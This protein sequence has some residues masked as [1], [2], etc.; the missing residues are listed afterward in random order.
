VHKSERA[1]T[2]VSCADATVRC[3]TY[4]EDIDSVVDKSTD[5]ETNWQLNIMRP[6]N[7]CETA[8]SQI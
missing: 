7:V 3:K 8:P 4:V 6:G 2:D 5:Y 1:V